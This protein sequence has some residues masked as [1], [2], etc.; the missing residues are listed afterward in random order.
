[1]VTET[2]N[3]KPVFDTSW[4]QSADMLVRTS[5]GG[6]KIIPPPDE[7]PIAAVTR[8]ML[9]KDAETIINKDRAATHGEAEDSFQTIGDYWSVYLSKQLGV[10]VTL[11]PMDVAQMMVLF[12]VARIHNN[13]K[14]LDNWVD[15]V[16]YS[17]LGGEIA[18][19]K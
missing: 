15:Q 14:H 7:K 11:S 16:G 2:G 10:G 18:L 17:A 9:L 8:N 1:M 13:P 5:T 4:K 19:A 12:K 3:E 6:Q